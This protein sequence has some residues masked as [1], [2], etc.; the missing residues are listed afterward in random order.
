MKD[1]LL[2]IAGCIGIIGFAALALAYLRGAYN[3]ATVESLREEINDAAR[4]EARLKE[5]LAECRGQIAVLT[6]RVAVLGEQVTQRAAVDQL[7]EQE[8]HNHEET[9]GV[10][11]R[12]ET[13][14]TGR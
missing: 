5:E 9:L 3:K 6:E 10:L 11:V 2:L 7:R 13:A 4:R 12:I 8:Q 1:V 14:L